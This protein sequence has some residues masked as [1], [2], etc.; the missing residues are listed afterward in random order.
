MDP[1]VIDKSYFLVTGGS[2]GIGAAI[3]KLM[4][5]NGYVPIIGYRTN[6]IYAEALAEELGGFAVKIDMNNKQTIDAALIIIEK[7][8]IDVS[9]LK[10][11]VLG[12]SPPPDL[13][14]FTELTS[15]HLLDQFNVNVVG[16]QILLANLIRR[17]FRKKKIGIVV[18]IL[19]SALGDNEQSPSKGIGAYI[20]AKGALR[21]MLT[22]C[23]SEYS[24]MKIRTVSPGFT[25]TKMLNVFDPRYLEMAEAQNKFSTAESVAK[26]IVGEIIS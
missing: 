24:W 16:S 9:R 12:A 10:G 11:V 21:T 23:A 5:T 7:T 22:V 4:P 1:L 18:G 25:K 8:I 26:L 20:I 6:Q 2:G 13:F 17:F 15:Q 14:S 3:C 19:T